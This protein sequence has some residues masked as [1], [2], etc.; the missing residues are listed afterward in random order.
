MHESLFHQ[1]RTLV[2]FEIESFKNRLDKLRSSHYPSRV[3]LDLID[4][5]DAELKARRSAI[6]QILADYPHDPKGAGKR[7]RSSIGGWS[8]S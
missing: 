7:L 5:L 8:T 2:T 3:A 1:L 4:Y 6:D